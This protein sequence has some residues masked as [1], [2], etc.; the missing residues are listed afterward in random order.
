MWLLF[1]PFKGEDITERSSLLEAGLKAG[2]SEDV[3][4]KMA[5]AIATNGIKEKL[6]QQTQ[7]A[8]DLGVSETLCS[9]MRFVGLVRH[10]FYCFY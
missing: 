8:L 9:E 4:V 2:I 6:K 10:I 3:V 7:E 5:D 1:F